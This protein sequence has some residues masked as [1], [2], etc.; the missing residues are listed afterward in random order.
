MTDRTGMDSFGARPSRDSSR[1]TRGAG[2]SE[3]QQGQLVRHATFGLGHIKEIS[4]AGLHTRAVVDFNTA[5]RKTLILEMAK[6][7][8]VGPK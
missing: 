5:G 2:S 8:A 6:L 3:F 1:E 7:Q 4:Q